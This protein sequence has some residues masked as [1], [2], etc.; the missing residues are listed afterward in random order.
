MKKG[1]RPTGR[2]PLHVERVSLLVKF[3]GVPAQRRGK[4]CD[5]ARGRMSEASVGLLRWQV[6][7]CVVLGVLLLGWSLVKGVWLGVAVGA[8]VGVLAA[9]AMRWLL[10]YEPQ[11]NQ[12]LWDRARGRAG[13]AAL[14][15]RRLAVAIGLIILSLGALVTLAFLD[16]STGRGMLGALALVAAIGT[17][18]W[19]WDRGEN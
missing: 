16:L 11:P 7:T 6:G 5:V 12:W 19:L 9:I 13:S 3:G 14:S 1:G 18:A 2:P 8:S 10:R 15:R 17:G 4:K